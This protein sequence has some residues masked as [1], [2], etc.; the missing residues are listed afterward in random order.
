[1]PSLP[2]ELSALLSPGAKVLWHG[3]PRPYVFIL[4]GLPTLAYGITWS[5]LGAIWYYAANI[6]FYMGWWRVVPLLSFPFIL[7]G[8]SFFFYP[9]RLGA[10]AR[11][12]R[13]VV[14]NLRIFIAELPLGRPPQLRVFA[15]EEMAPPQ[16]VRRSDRPPLY[17]VIFTLRAQKNPHL[18]PRLDAGFFGLD[19]GDAAANAINAA[20]NP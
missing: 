14:T 13:Y 19:D 8:F 18:T 20:T 4:R 5:V 17:D 15:A 2:T 10:R 11:R 3:R 7:A 1:M 16:V 12:T 6:A 9:I